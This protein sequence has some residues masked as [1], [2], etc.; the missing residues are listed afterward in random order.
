MSSFVIHVIINRNV[1]NKIPMLNVWHVQHALE[2]IC[3]C[4]TYL[5]TFARAMHVQHALKFFFYW[6]NN[7]VK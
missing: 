2:Y 5:H 7:N 4:S 3:S 6:N 1:Y